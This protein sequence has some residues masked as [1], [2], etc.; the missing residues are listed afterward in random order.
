MKSSKVLITGGTG[1]VGS[2]LARFFLSKGFEVATTVRESSNL[3]RIAEISDRI[4]KFKID[5]NDSGMV[6]NL[7]ET[8]QPS[9]IIHTAAYGGY[10]F[11]SNFNSIINTNFNATVNLVEAYLKSE[12]ELLINTGSSSEYGFK[13][14][15]MSENDPLDPVGAYSV[16]KAASTMYCRSRSVEE[17]KKIVTFRLFSAYGDYEEAHRLIP[18]LI[19]STLNKTK[20]NLNNPNSKRDFIYVQDINNAYLRLI[21]VIDKIENGAIFNLG[22]GK[23]STIKN[24]VSIISELFN[25]NIDIE[26]SGKNGRIS[27]KAKKWVADTNKL[28]SILGY[29]PRYSLH[30]GLIKTCEWFSE[31]KEKYEVIENSK[32]K[33]FSK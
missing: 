30:D 5:L 11:E 4:R 7:L 24:V 26:W 1:F 29:T 22:T 21:E 2:N 8:V 17:D 14:S 28:S 10:H 6:L 27:D 23:E 31:N 20:I 19:T 25:G 13:D 32:L 33:K 16:S 9:V 18:Y 3:W 12:C 15:P